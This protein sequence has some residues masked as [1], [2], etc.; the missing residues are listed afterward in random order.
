MPGPEEE[1]AVER[2]QEFVA[3]HERVVWNPVLTLPV[4]SF[5]FTEPEAVRI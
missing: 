1:S 5:E 4:K 2:K 3:G